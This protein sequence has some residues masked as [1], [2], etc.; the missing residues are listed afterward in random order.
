M[1]S[2]GDASVLKNLDT[3]VPVSAERGAVMRRDRPVRNLIFNLRVE[4]RQ[5]V[6]AKAGIDSS[7]PL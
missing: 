3:G 2:M 7:L 4:F 5:E 1:G 6:V